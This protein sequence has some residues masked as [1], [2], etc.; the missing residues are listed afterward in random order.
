MRAVELGVLQLCKALCRA[1]PSS[2]ADSLLAKWA[3]T[4]KPKRQNCISSFTRE[5]SNWEKKQKRNSI[6][7]R[8]LRA[9]MLALPDAILRE[10]VEAEMLAGGKSRS[11]AKLNISHLKAGEALP[12]IKRSVSRFSRSAVGGSLE[13]VTSPACVSL[14]PWGMKKIVVDGN[15]THIPSLCRRQCLERTHEQCREWRRVA[16]VEEMKR[17]RFLDLVKIATGG[18]AK[19]RR[20]ADCVAGFLVNDSSGILERIIRGSQVEDNSASSSKL[21][22]LGLL[23]VVKT[24]LKRGYDKHLEETFDCPSHSIKFSLGDASSAPSNFY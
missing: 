22:L 4:A 24:L 3:E 6:E 19:L 16:G 9:T 2:L 15:E 13:F 12:Q 10:A 20:A 14:I 7:K 21:D 11:K 18:E 17:S 1:D 8:M 23:E 5:L